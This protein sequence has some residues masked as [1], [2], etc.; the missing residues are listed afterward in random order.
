MFSTSQINSKIEAAY[1]KA[2]KSPDPMMG[3]SKYIGY[4]EGVVK[5]AIFYLDDNGQSDMAKK[6]LNDI[7]KFRP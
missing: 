3:L 4:L 1:E 2:K 6:L 7:D 5:D